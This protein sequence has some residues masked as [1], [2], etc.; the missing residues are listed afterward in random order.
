VYS[1]VDERSGKVDADHVDLY[2]E[3]GITISL[4]ETHAYS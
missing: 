2:E 4:T 1:V 3:F